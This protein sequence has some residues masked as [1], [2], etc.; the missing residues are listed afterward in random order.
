[1]LEVS[2]PLAHDVG[3]IISPDHAT[4]MQLRAASPGHNR[5]SGLLV[6]KD[7]KKW[8]LLWVALAL[9]PSPVFPHQGTLGIRE[10]SNLFL[11]YCSHS[12]HVHLSR[13][14]QKEGGE[15]KEE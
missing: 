1:M 7:I 14:S 2:D 3:N 8:F 10:G 15:G 6:G 13:C 5:Y 4:I 9:R 12:R 11:S